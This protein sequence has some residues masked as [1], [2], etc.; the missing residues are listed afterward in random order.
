MI[1]SSTAGWVRDGYI[2]QL[3]VVT[4]TS[5]YYSDRGFRLVNL[6]IYGVCIAG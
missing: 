5:F 2:F 3:A 4:R 6:Y 1:L